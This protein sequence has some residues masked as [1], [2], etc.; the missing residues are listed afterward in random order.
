[1]T[2]V[3]QIMQLVFHSD[4]DG[5]SYTGFEGKYK[6]IGEGKPNIIP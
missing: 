2:S 4:Y 1:M 3:H 6:F 5:G